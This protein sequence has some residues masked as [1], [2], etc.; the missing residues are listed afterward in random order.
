MLQ[1]DG[2]FKE[3]PS[4][5]ELMY[6][7]I[8]GYPFYIPRNIMV[9]VPE[10]IATELRQNDDLMNKGKELTLENTRGLAALAELPELGND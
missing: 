2:S 10:A 9:E 8:N 7:N 1:S 3:F 6:F 5:G 4:Y